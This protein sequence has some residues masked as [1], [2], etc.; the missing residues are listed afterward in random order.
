LELE[1]PRLLAMMAD[2][3]KKKKKKKNPLSLSRP[4]T[5]RLAELLIGAISFPYEKEGK[6]D[7]D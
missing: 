4:P 7:R 3:K 5:L 2:E 1:L 6:I